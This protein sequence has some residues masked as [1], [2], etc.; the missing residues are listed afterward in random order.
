M[1]ASMS[2]EESEEWGMAGAVVATYLADV[3]GMN[4]AG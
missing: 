1:I 4:E 3:C 2:A